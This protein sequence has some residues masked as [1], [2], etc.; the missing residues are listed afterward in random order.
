MLSILPD[1]DAMQ[2]PYTTIQEKEDG[3]I[4]VYSGYCPICRTAWERDAVFDQG[5][6]MMI[7]DSIK[8]R[9]SH[10]QN[11]IAWVLCNQEKAPININGGHLQWK[12]NPGDGINS[13]SVIESRLSKVPG[14][15][16]GIILSKNNNL[17]CFDFDHALNEKGEIIN[18]QVQELLEILSTFTEI[19]SSGR[20]LHA[21]VNAELNEDETLAEYGFKKE[22]CDGKF[23]PARF[24]K[25]T[26]DCLEGYDLPVQTFGK[27]QFETI[28]KR[29]SSDYIA[30]PRQKCKVSSPHSTTDTEWDRVLDEAGIIHIKASYEGKTRTYPDGTSRTAIESY[31]IPCPNRSAHTDEEKRKGKFGPDAAILTK[32]DDGTSS[33]SCNHN[34]C[35]PA[36]RPNLLQKLWDEIREI[37]VGE[38]RKVLEFYKGVL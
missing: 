27:R 31:R 34:S 19:S 26:G 25:L 9:F 30:L 10:W 2:E 29:I 23:Y 21:F 11:N 14:A 38:A 7:P 6:S 20:G 16:F 8:T 17:T 35:D 5:D 13:L 22:F 15:G 24:I 3:E 37:R 32:W 33:V 1:V 36:N 28:R 4:R 12:E 18:L